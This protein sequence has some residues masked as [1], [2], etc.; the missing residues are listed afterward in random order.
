[1]GQTGFDSEFKESASMQCVVWGHLK[2]NIQKFIWRKQLRSRC[3]I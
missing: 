3:L 2:H 1:M